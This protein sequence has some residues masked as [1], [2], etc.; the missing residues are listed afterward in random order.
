MSELRRFVGEQQRQF[1]FL[2]GPKD[3]QLVS[4]H[5]AARHVNVLKPPLGLQ[6]LPAKQAEMM[7]PV[8]AKVFTY[9]KV[10]VCDVTFYV[11]EVV[12]RTERDIVKWVLV[13]L[14]QGYA[15]RLEAW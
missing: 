9:R 11:P 6:N 12:Y 15:G 14:A 8:P 13:M 7:D 10:T 2:G 5:E 3:G 1:L 4:Q